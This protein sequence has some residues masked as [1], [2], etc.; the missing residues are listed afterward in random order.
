M[1][2]NPDGRRGRRKGE[3]TAATIHVHF[4]V[5]LGTEPREKREESSR[6]KAH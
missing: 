3:K 6:R 2:E 1:T 5:D 4:I